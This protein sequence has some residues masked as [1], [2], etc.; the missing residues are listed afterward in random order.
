MLAASLL[1]AQLNSSAL[2]ALW[3]S[4]AGNGLKGGAIV[5]S[6]D[7]VWSRANIDTKKL[8]P[9]CSV[10]KLMTAQVIFQ[11]IAERKLSL[12]TQPE[13]RKFTV[14]Q[15]LT[16]TSGLPNMDGA[17]GKA[18]DGTALIYRTQNKQLN[19]LENVISTCMKSGVAKAP[20]T[21]YDYNNLDFLFLQKLI[22]DREKMPFSRI[23]QRRVFAK[24]GMKS[25]RLAEFGLTSKG[26]LVDSPST[27]M[28]L[29]IYGGAGAVVATLPDIAKWMVWS[30]KQDHS[31]ITQGSQYGGF[32]GFGGY[33]YDTESL[34]TPEGIF[35]RPGAIG[36]YRWQVS[37]LPK[38]KIAVAVFSVSDTTQ[39]GSFFEKKGLV[40]DLAKSAVNHQ[41]SLTA[42]ESR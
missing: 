23:L 40:V 14:K 18:P 39:V 5:V 22:E 41:Y 13:G 24:A 10:T 26:V 32:Q 21:N 7:A 17:L 12:D 37:F 4:G 16:H 33:A 8:V 31:P 2:D 11:L 3:D 36:N 29:G 30:L 35:E 27:N 42:F 28:N 20:G 6:G 1:F 25:A 19:S 9:I 38:R 15:L 34:G